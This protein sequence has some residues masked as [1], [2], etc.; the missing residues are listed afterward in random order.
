MTGTH[1]NS[2]HGDYLIDDLARDPTIR[3]WNPLSGE[4]L[5]TI[6]VRRFNDHLAVTPSG[7]Y[8]VS[9]LEFERDLVYVVQTADCQLTLTPAEFEQR[10]HWKNDPKTVVLKKQP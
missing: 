3:F 8:R 1:N 10:F 2:G 6:L 9:P 5:G 7:H 4:S